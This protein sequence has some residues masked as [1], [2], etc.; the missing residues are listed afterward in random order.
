MNWRQGVYA[1]IGGILGFLTVFAAHA[2]VTVIAI[3][4]ISFVGLSTPTAGQAWILGLVVPLMIIA[5]AA[6]AAQSLG[7]TWRRSLVAGIAAFVMAAS[8]IHAGRSNYSPFNQYETLAFVCSAAVAVLLATVNKGDTTPVGLMVTIGITT[9]L[10][11]GAAFFAG[12]G[13]V[14]AL[15]AWCLLP[16]FAGLF[17]TIA[18]TLPQKP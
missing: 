17:R 12:Y 14:I 16:V 3:Q 10:V 5:G 13:F 7:A 6:L 11:L 9:L 18:S 15:S 4:S 2:V 1:L 8:I